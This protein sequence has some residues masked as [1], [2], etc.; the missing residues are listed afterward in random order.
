MLFDHDFESIL[1]NKAGFDTI[2]VG[3][4]GFPGALNL[5]SGTTAARTTTPVA[6]S[7]RWNTTLT[8]LESYDGTQWS[9]PLLLTSQAAKTVL[10]APIGAAGIPTF[11]LLALGEQSNVVL[12]A[13]ISTQV[14]SFNGTNWINSSILASNAAGII[15]VGN[16][17]GGTA[18]TFVS[19]VRY[20]ANFV[21]SLGTSNIVVT[22]YDQADNSIVIPDKVTT[23][24]GN[25]V[26]VVVVGN[27]KSLKVVV[28][29]NGSALVAGGSTPSSIITA[30]QG[31]TV[32]AAA[33][34]LNF[35]GSTVVTDAGGGTTTVSIGARF[36]N[37]ANS[38]DTP[39]NADWI[40]NAFAPTITDPTNPG[41]NVRSFSNT[42]EVGVGFTVSIPAGAT[43]ATYRIRGRAAA[44]IA[45]T[46][47]VVQYR[48]YFRS[49]GNLSGTAGV[50]AWVG[51][52]DLT[53]ILI[54]AN[55]V[56]FQSYVMS[57][58]LASAGLIAGQSYQ[59]ELTRRVAP[60]TGTQ[61]SAAFLLAETT[62]EFA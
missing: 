29:A 58:T 33:T 11:R 8:T 55:N 4:T 17:G 12:T 44:A 10:A 3:G 9:S 6:G 19:G 36:T 37:Y 60:A 51:P 62:I 28:V 43:V 18:W 35:I 42:I 47:N 49:L 22:V 38:F 50:G 16:A 5:P 26:T 23:P 45:G 31:I 24:D 40:I 21:H 53:N 52:L 20:T 7:F 25:T 14:L 1:P 57:G 2:T 34:K 41:V 59:F 54:P 48:I 15:G 30:Y 61:L 27:T 13:P 46:T 56:F 32:S 39:N